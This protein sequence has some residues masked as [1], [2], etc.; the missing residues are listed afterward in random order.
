LLRAEV[1]FNKDYFFRAAET[2]M[3]RRSPYKGNRNTLLQSMKISCKIKKDK[4]K[5]KNG[6]LDT[7]NIRTKKPIE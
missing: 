2:D 3:V 4:S 6:Q 1:A 5:N 7:N